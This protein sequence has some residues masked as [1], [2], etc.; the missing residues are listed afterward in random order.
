MVWTRRSLL[1]AGGLAG[2]LGLAG[3]GG[4]VGSGGTESTAPPTTAESSG[5]S[6]ARR[7]ERDPLPAAAL[8]V[9]PIRDP[10]AFLPGRFFRQ[11]PAAPI[12]DNER[13]LHPSVYDEFSQELWDRP[14][15]LFGVD[16]DA[17]TAKYQV[18][19]HQVRILTGTFD[20][21]RVSEYV[22]RAFEPV[23]Q[24]YDLDLLARSTG[25]TEQLVAV[26]E[27]HLVAGR[28]EDASSALEVRFGAADPLALV[29]EHFWEAAVSVA[30]ADLVSITDRY[31]QGRSGLLGSVAARGFA[32]T[33]ED[34]RIRLTAPFVFHRETVADTATV[35]E[36]LDSFRGLE[37]Y[38]H[39]SL[40]RRGRRVTLDATTPTELFDKGVSGRPE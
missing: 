26:G 7:L 19:G 31:N 18:P 13:R 40:S 35:R 9:P 10:P 4:E 23:G 5:A 29:D 11:V 16:P 20:P 12:T 34:E 8:W 21:G 6:G 36:W 17:I 24:R 25:R 3:C 14:G 27:D 2:T 22:G 33:F 15:R 38:E 32:W 30:D 28:R 39:V 37:T 1:R